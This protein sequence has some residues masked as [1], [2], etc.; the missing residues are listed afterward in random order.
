MLIYLRQFLIKLIHY[1]TDILHSDKYITMFAKTIVFF[2]VS[3]TVATL[4]SGN[5]HTSSFEA[6]LAE[7]FQLL[8]LQTV[9]N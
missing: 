2:L 8:S 1:V 7:N 6:K 5:K 3:L 9:C 4:S